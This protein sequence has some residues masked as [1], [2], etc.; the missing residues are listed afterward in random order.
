MHHLQRQSPPSCSIPAS[1]RSP[2]GHLRFCHPPE[3]RACVHC[4]VWSFSDTSPWGGQ[5]DIWQLQQSVASQSFPSCKPSKPAHS[6]HTVCS[7]R[8]P[9]ASPHPSIPRSLAIDRP[10][11][12]PR[13]LCLPVL[14]PTSVVSILFV[15]GDG[16]PLP[17]GATPATDILHEHNV[18]GGG[19]RIG[20]RVNDERIQLVGLPTQPT[21]S[22]Q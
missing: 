5:F 8:R 15:C 6:A 21:A 20:Q 7:G 12:H 10:P 1:L 14:T 2:K 22:K 9:A 11:L 16:I 18:P 13:F 4:G 17:T 3:V 19:S